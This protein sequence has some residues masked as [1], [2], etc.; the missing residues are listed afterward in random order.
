MKIIEEIKNLIKQ[1]NFSELEN[2]LLNIFSENIDLSGEFVLTISDSLP[3]SKVDLKLTFLKLAQEH[4][5]SLSKKEDLL[6][7]LKRIFELQPKEETKKEI[8]NI[9]KSIYLT[10]EEKKFLEKSE[11][12]YADINNFLKAFNRLENFLYNFIPNKIVYYQNF[13]YQIISYDFL[14]DQIELKKI[15]ENKIVKYPIDFVFN[16][17]SLKCETL[18]ETKKITNQRTERKV[19][20]KIE[21]KEEEVENIFYSYL[22]RIDEFVYLLKNRLNLLKEKFKIPQILLRILHLLSLKERKG[23]TTFLKKMVFKILEEENIEE[24]YLTTIKERILSL[25]IFKQNEKDALECFFKKK[26][27]KVLYHTK[28]AI[29]KAKEELKILNEK[30]KKNAEDLA[31]ARSHGDLSENYEYKIAKEERQRLLNWLKQ[32]SEELKISAPIDFSKI[33]GEFVEPGTKI[34]IKE[35][36]TDRELDYLLLGPFDIRF[37]NYQDKEHIISY[38]SPLGEKFLNKKVGEIVEFNNEKYQI[39]KIEKALE[40]ELQDKDKSL[41]NNSL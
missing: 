5:Y 40:E 39:L 38:C 29:E 17:F 24:E 1:K 13:P 31:R 15:D 19:K 7:V 25:S 33:T 9:L 22:E 37:L 10:E 30:L 28:L 36:K 11:V 26:E 35:L 23:Y 14:F 27:R 6:K 4:F 32:L 20:N 8:I 16:N 12:F 3:K 18:K 34:K 21:V 2:F 41:P